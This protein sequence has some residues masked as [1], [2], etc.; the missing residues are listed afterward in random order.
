MITGE[1]KPLAEILG[2]IEGRERVL[3]LGCRGCVTV[4]NLGGEKEAGLLASALRIARKKTGRPAAVEDATVERQCDPEY[5]AGLAGRVAAYDAVVS[6][7]C[8]VGPQFV[9]QQ[10]PGLPVFPGINTTFLGGALG[11]GVW[12]ERCQG[13]GNCLI[14][15]FGGLCPIARCAKSLMNGPCGGSSG[16]KCE[17]GPEVDCVWQLIVERMEALG[18]LAELGRVFPVKNWLS[19]RDGGPRRRVREDLQS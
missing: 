7:A 5:V 11:H 2:M 17:I 12:S 10:F 18:R 1:A 8:G 9:A 19:A 6:L 14:H 3:V 15:H 16:G 13:C 4:S